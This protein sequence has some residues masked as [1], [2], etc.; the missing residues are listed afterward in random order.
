MADR[1]GALEAMAQRCLGNGFERAGLLVVDFIDMQVYVEPALDRGT[2]QRVELALEVRAHLC[3]PAEQAGMVRHDRHKVIEEG[4][5]RH[6][7]ER[8]ERN[9]LECDPLLPFLAH[10]GEDIEGNAVLG[11]ER[12]EMGADQPSFP[13]GWR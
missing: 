7:I 10:L 1:D 4:R 9:R 2:E 12:V 5:V 3:D 6:Q 13:S 8:E 11:R